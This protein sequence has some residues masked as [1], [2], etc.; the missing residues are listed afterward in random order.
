MRLTTGLNAHTFSIAAD[1]SKFAYDVFTSSSL[2][3]SLP[4]P[5][6]GATEAQAVPVT[7]G[8]QVTEFATPSRDG[9]WVYYAS[10]VSGHSQI[11]RQ[12]LP[13]GDPEQ[14]TTDPVDHFS[15]MP[16]PDGREVAFHSWQS[17][18]RDIYV[19]PLDGGPVQQ[20]TS[21]PLQEAQP[22]WSPDG[23]ALAYNIFGLPG[24]IW[25]VRRDASGRW[26]T[27]VERVPHGSWAAWSPDGKTIAF[28][29]NFLGGSLMLIDPDSGAPRI[30]VDSAKNNGVHVLRTV[31]SEDGRT[32][33]FKSVDGQ[34]RASFW[35]V[36][37]AGGQPKLL[38]RFDD[39][40]RPSYRP[41]WSEGS[42]RMYFTIHD[43]ESDVWVMDAAHP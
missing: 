5:P 2:V 41:E 20:V 26:G 9:K 18:S 21:G 28:A 43:N 14:L 4:F 8:T 12:R 7:S 34:A 37:L 35:S 38:L 31:W 42:G 15:P 13:S 6:N 27:P 17:G 23:R 25:V 22:A 33:Y 30:V 24:G 36:P 10:D 40:T 1:G 39:V 3:W 11:Y 16:S 29:S 32:L 19:M